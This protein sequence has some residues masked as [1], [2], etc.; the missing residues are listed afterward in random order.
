MV[1]RRNHSEAEKRL[2][3]LLCTRWYIFENITDFV[4]NFRFAYSIYN[5]SLF[6]LMYCSS[7]WRDTGYPGASTMLQMLPGHLFFW[8][9]SVENFRYHLVIPPHWIFQHLYLPFAYFRRC[10]ILARKVLEAE[11]LAEENSSAGEKSL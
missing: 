2:W 5:W 7:L 4:K 6:S 8:K 10:L 3:K 11:Q 1:L 9:F